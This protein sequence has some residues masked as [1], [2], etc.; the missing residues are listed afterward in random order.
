[1]ASESAAETFSSVYRDNH[2]GRRW[3]KKFCSGQ[4]SY[5]E[6]IVG[7]YVQSV[8]GF[9][10]EF[11][12]PP[13]IVDLGCGDFHVGSRIREACAHYV[14]CDVVPELIEHNRKAFARLQ[15]EFACLNIVDDPLPR[16][17]VVFIRQ[18][19][20]HL[21]NAQI[22]CVLPKLAQ[23]RFVVITEHLPGDPAFSPNRDHQFGS[24][25]RVTRNSGVVLTAPPFNFKATS[26]RLLCSV[27]YGKDVIKTIAYGV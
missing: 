10:S 5:E 7:P 17:E 8:R 12:Q 22:A 4:G 2:W 24:G 13:R 26:E 1:M 19:L 3:G 27:Q 14:A 9:L 15:V 23:Y 20:Q 25:T 11:S 21:A 6:P 18:V 16:G